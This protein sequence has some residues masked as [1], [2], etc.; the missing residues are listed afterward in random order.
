MLV[1]LISALVTNILFQFNETRYLGLSRSPVTVYNHEDDSNHDDDITSN[2]MD[3]T[4]T[5]KK[6]CELITQ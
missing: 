6:K 3:E 4:A 5:S 1:E 2:V